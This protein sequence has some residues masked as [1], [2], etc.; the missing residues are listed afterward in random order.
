DFRHLKLRYQKIA[1]LKFPRCFRR[2][3]SISDLSIQH[4]SNPH[5]Q[6]EK[7]LPS[8]LLTLLVYMCHLMLQD[9]KSTRLNSSHVSISYAVFCLKKKRK[10]TCATHSND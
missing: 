5:R 3:C 9:R 6:I 8:Y 2:S 7:L 4:K 10:K 1:S